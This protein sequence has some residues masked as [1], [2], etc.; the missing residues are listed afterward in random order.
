VAIDSFSFLL[1]VITAL[2]LPKLSTNKLAT[3]LDKMT[4]V[5]RTIAEGECN[6][7]QRIEK[8]QIVADETD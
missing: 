4:E 1:I 5:I 8:Y 6:L 3:R 2:N 7:R